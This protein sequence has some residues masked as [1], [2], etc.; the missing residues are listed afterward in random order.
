MMNTDSSRQGKR[1]I[2]DG[3]SMPSIDDSFLEQNAVPSMEEEYCDNRDGA[4]LPTSM[5]S[6]GG[7]R[8][9]LMTGRVYSDSDV[10][11]ESEASIGD[12]TCEDTVPSVDITVDK[13]SP[14]K[15]PPDDG[16]STK[17]GNPSSGKS[18]D[19][20]SLADEFR[21]EEHGKSAHKESTARTKNGGPRRIT[22]KRS[23]DGTSRSDPSDVGVDDPL[24]REK[25]NIDSDT[26]LS[27]SHKKTFIIWMLIV[28]VVLA[29]GGGVFTG[30]AI[31]NGS[32]RSVTLITPA[33]TSPPTLQPTLF[34]R[35]DGAN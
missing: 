6:P 1:H 22:V 19:P 34:A 4:I 16:K 13:E 32:D 3:Q 15:Q 5:M 27:K 8:R 20:P 14:E 30:V 10:L 23:R 9:L 33:P 24:V 25:S 21:D 28:L 29:Y 31:S 11:S 18:P 26:I 35:D 7:R 2:P 12:N 17:A